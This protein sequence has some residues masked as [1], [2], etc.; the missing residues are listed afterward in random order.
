V[1]LARRSSSGGSC[2]A[3]A[4]GYAQTTKCTLIAGSDKS[5]IGGYCRRGGGGGG[6]CVNSGACTVDFLPPLV[7]PF[8]RPYTVILSATRQ[9]HGSPD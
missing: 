1:H 4:K 3:R 9:P 2:A 7:I 6:G 8:L 5:V